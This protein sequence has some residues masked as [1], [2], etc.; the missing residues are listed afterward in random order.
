MG[1][2]APV[3]RPRDAEHIVLHQAVAEHLEFVARRTQF[4]E[5]V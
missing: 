2:V 3:Y 1:C 5:D 4:D